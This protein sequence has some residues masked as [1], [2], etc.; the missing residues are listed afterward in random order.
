[1]PATN[2]GSMSANQARRRL[3][4]SSV[5]DAVV[6]SGG[7][8]DVF[9]RIRVSDP[10]TISDSKFLYSDTGQL[11]LSKTNGVGASAAYVSTGNTIRLRVGT[12]SGEYTIRQTRQYHQYIPGKSQ[13][14]IATGVIGA[15]KSNVTQRMGYFDDNDGI[16]L[17]QTSSGIYIVKRTSTSGSPVDTRVLQS[18]QDGWNLD[19]LDGSGS[20]DNPS[21]IGLDLSKDI[22]LV[23][24]FQWL[25]VGEVLVGCNIDGI[26]HWCHK[27]TAANALV[28]VYMLTPNLPVRYEIRNTGIAD[29]QTD[30]YQICSAIISE[31]GYEAS[32]F[33]HAV[34]NAAG[35]GITVGTTQTC[36]L[37]IRLKS[38][39]QSKANRVTVHI[40]DYSTMAVGADYGIW[41]AQ[42]LSSSTNITGGTWTSVE[43]DSAVEYST[44]VGTAFNGGHS[45]KRFFQSSNQG[46]FAGSIASQAI[47]PAGARHLTLT[48]NYDST[49]SQVFAILATARTGAGTAWGA[50]GWREVY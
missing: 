20:K 8:V 1:M 45:I 11:W 30:L 23:I 27:F 26:T 41:I 48:Q 21:G 42:F 31:G 13:L 49:D 50:L 22:I 34:S 9:N 39:F 5:A 38:S 15:P 7:S 40:V 14:I 4:D 47:N 44:N 3:S 32:G 2:S 29:S 46:S 17:E 16:F 33:E 12:V 24:N 6:I 10:L 28:G 43:A 19:K 36:I 35:S 37:A 25:G 18:G